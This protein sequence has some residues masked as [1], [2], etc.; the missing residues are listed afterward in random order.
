MKNNLFLLAI[1]SI[2]ILFIAS[3][4][5]NSI[6]SQPKSVITKGY[7]YENNSKWNSKSIRLDKELEKAIIIYTNPGYTVKTISI[8]TYSNVFY[9][10]VIYEKY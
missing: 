7:K 2:F 8:T 4:T 3:T 10:V 1:I 9:A 6:L 5:P